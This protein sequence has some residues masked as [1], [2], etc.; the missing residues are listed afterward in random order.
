M[1]GDLPK[2]RGAGQSG[3]RMSGGRAPAT[4]K[5]KPG[6]KANKSSKTALAKPTRKAAPPLLCP[7][8]GALTETVTICLSSSVKEALRAL[9]DAD[10]RTLSSYI[11]LVLEDY[12][13]E[14]ADKP[15]RSG[16]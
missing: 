12:L 7:R 4:K 2:K 5:A 11:T 14:R 3:K 15:K 6:T 8:P 10:R 1:G 9:A 16:K 13:A